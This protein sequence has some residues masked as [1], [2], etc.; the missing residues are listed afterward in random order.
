MSQLAQKPFVTLAQYLEAEELSAE[1]HQYCNGTV[2]AMAG[3]TMAHARV[4]TNLG[5][6]LFAALRGRPCRPFSEAQRIVVRATGLWTY[7]DQSVICGTPQRDEQDRQGAT[8]PKVLF[9]VLSEST[10][11]YDQ[12]EKFDHYATIP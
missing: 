7:P 11:G 9:E 8:N 1:K 4:V 2:V 3:G 12:G 5:G 6:I 10:A